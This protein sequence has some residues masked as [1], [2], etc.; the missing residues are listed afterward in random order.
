VKFKLTG[1]SA[2][3]SNLVAHLRTAKASS[4]VTGTS[5]EATQTCTA[6]SGDTFRYDTTAKQYIFNLSTKGMSAGTWSLR[7]DLGDGV[8]HTVKVSLK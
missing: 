7:A 5:V 6:N 8:D 1:A 2:A 3:I 4:T